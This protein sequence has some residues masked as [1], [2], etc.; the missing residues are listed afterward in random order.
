MKCPYYIGLN[1]K[2]NKKAPFIRIYDNKIAMLV[3]LYGEIQNYLDS[4]QWGNKMNDK[5]KKPNPLVELLNAAKNKK[6]TLNG[7]QHNKFLVLWCSEK[8][9]Q[10]GNLN[11]F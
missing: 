7:K 4:L 3:T 9:L 10:R 8:I 6:Q 11:I 2:N 1:I 5:N